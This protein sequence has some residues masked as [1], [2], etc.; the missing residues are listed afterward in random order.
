MWKR[1][2]RLDRRL[3]VIDFVMAN[4]RFIASGTRA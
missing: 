4:G 1:V 3:P 2:A